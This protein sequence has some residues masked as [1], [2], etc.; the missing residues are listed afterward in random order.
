[1]V[2]IVDNF[3]HFRYLDAVP[4]VV[5]NICR[6]TFRTDVL[7]RIDSFKKPWN[8]NGVLKMVLNL[9]PNVVSRIV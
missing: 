7:R 8:W 5:I 2:I 9:K 6:C 3:L 4:H 1:M